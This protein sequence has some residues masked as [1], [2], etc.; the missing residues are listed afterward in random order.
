MRRPHRANVLTRRPGGKEHT[1]R[2]IVAPCVTLRHVVQGYHTGDFPLS[3]QKNQVL[4]QTHWTNWQAR[5]EDRL[6]FEAPSVGLNEFFS[7]SDCALLCTPASAEAHIH[8]TGARCLLLSFFAEGCFARVHLDPS[9]ECLC[10]VRI[11]GAY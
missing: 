4:C 3:I 6:R 1:M 11:S 10:V 5:V 7:G 8:H 2:G 9:C